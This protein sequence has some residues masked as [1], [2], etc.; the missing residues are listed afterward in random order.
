MSASVVEVAQ[1]AVAAPSSRPIYLRLADVLARHADAAGSEGLPSARALA[2]EV[3]LNRATVTAAYRELARRGVIVLRSGRAARHPRALARPFEAT[4]AEPPPGAVD[5]AR[6][7]PNRTLLPAGK[8][9]GWLGLGGGEGDAV[10]QYGD[11]WGY[12]PLREWI[13]ER[14]RRLGVAAEGDGVLLTAGVQHALDLLLRALARPGDEVAVEDPTYSGLPPLLAL[15]GLRPVG[16]RVREDGLHAAEVAAALRARRPLVAILTPTLHNPSGV[17]L[18]EARRRAIVALLLDAGA[19]VV[20]ELFDPALVSS[21]PVPPPLA[22]LDERVLAVGSFSKALFPGLRVGW[23]AGPRGLVE[24]VAAVKRASDLSGSPFLEATAWGLCRRGELEAQYERLRRA[25]A[26][27]VAIVLDGLE[28]AP[29]GVSWSRPRGGFSVLVT[30]P[31]ALSASAVAERAAALGVA[32]LP[33]PAMSVSGR[34]DVVRLA[35]AAVEGERLRRGVLAF[36]AAL[37]PA[38]VPGPLV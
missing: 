4:V 11:A 7:A 1:R 15:H 30:L 26:R 21:G 18:D 8:V 35:F 23:L 36:V 20:E 22:A 19:I 16:L 31:R 2:A 6:Y 29:A 25:A 38:Q 24:R 13:G 17:V 33:G 32:V 34:D 14:L 3:G 5:L 9:F 37:S 12:A 28:S 27:R 10:A